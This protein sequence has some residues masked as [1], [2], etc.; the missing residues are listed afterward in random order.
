MFIERS[1][2]ALREMDVSAS[3]YCVFVVTCYIRAVVNLS[4]HNTGPSV[5]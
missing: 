5:W 3:R 1:M 4:P 2:T